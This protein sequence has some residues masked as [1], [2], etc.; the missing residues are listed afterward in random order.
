MIK[1][2]PNLSCVRKAAKKARNIHTNKNPERKTFGV[3]VVI[4]LGVFLSDNYHT[5]LSLC[6]DGTHH[7]PP[8]DAVPQT[9]DPQSESFV[10]D[11]TAQY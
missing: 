10:Q 9:H 2:S 6:L 7:F 1:N 4:L 3:F 11:L 8:L 5:Q